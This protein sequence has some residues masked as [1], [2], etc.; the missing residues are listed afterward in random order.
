[1][2]AEHFDKLRDHLPFGQVRTNVTSPNSQAGL[3]DLSYTG[4]QTLNRCIQIQKRAYIPVTSNEF[5]GS[6]DYS[7]TSITTFPQ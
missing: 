4:Q 2:P 1:M 5:G 3:T 6:N 7:K